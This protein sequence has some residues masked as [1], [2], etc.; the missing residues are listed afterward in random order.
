M[1]PQPQSHVLD[2]PYHQEDIKPDA[3]LENKARSPSQYQDGDKMSYSEKEALKQLPEASIWK[4]FSCTGEYDHMVLIGYIDGLLINLPKIPDY[5]IT[6]RLNT[7]F[8][9][10]ASIWYT[11][12]KGIHGRRNWPWWKSQMRNIK[13]LTQIPRELDHAMECICNKS[14]TLDEIENTLQDVRKRTNIGKYFQYKR[15]SL[16]EKQPFRVDCKNKTKERVAEVNKKNN[17]CH[18]FPEEESPT[19]DAESDSMGNAI[20]EQYNKDQDPEEEFLVKY[21]EET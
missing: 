1:K 9:G 16:K 15:S 2:N 8:K 13:L 7:V 12:M 14:F 6:T 17:S 10:N 18:N 3:L 4:K 5:W 11:E 20:R 19:E 21:Q